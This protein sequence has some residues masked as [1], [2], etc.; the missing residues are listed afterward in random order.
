MIT[1]NGE[2]P[3]ICQE[4]GAGFKQNYVLKHHITYYT[5]EKVIYQLEVS[6][7]KILGVNLK[8]ILILDQS[9]LLARGV[10]QNFH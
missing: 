2:K 4:C 1:Y 8:Q 10:E 7:E 3:F 9:H 6:S 5:K